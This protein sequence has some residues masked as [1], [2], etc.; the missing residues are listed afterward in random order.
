MKKVIIVE[1]DTNDGDYISE[2]S[3]LE[4]GDVEKVQKIVNVISEK[5]Q[6][7]NWPSSEYIDE[8][9][10]ELYKDL[11]TEEEIEFMDS[12]VPHGEHGVH[13]INS[14][15]ILEVVSDERIF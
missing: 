14:I 1:A 12:F 8:T 7:Y 11:L 6:D 2:I 9:A 3:D 10:E 15:R 13:S 4:P 5:G